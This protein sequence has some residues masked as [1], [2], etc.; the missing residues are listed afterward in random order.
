MG[1]KD[2]FLRQVADAHVAGALH[3]PGGRLFQADQ[4][5][6]Q[7]GFAHTVRPHQANAGVVRDAERNIAEDI[8][9]AKGFTHVDGSNERHS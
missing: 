8:D 9:R 2:G 4:D 3:L 1:F 5:A 6:Q 7:G